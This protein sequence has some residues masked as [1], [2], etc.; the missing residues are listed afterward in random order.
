MVVP[1]LSSY[2]H[3]E[4]RCL[5]CGGTTALHFILQGDFGSAWRANFFVCVLLALS[6][7][8]VNFFVLFRIF[9]IAKV[10]R[11]IGNFYKAIFRRNL[12]G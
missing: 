9:A 7:M 2:P 12:W 5:F 8:N 3:P 1:F 11:G 4:G 6:L 10:V